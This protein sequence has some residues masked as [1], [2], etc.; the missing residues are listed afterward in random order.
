MLSLFIVDSNVVFWAPEVKV[1][2]VTAFQLSLTAPTHLP[3]SSLP[4]SSLAIHFSHLESPVIIQRADSGP[5]SR[6]LSQHVDLG[7]ISAS[8]IPEEVTA[9][10]QWDLGECKV[11]SG[12]LSSDL[13]SLLK[14]RLHAP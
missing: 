12:T 1:G 13:P 4:F 3:I 6:S 5:S 14:V 11:F 7:H 8:E 2:E 10:L 9:D